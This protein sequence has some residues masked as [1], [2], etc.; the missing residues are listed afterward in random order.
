MMRPRYRRG[1]WRRSLWQ[2]LMD[3][4]APLGDGELSNLDRMDGLR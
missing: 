3:R 4:I 2:R 1:P